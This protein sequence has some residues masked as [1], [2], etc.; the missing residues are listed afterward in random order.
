M[1]KN[2]REAAERYAANHA[3]MMAM[4][5]PR[6]LPYTYI[7]VSTGAAGM[8]N[9]AWNRDAHTLA[10]AYL[11]EHD[12][13]P[14]TE[15]WLRSVGFE[16]DAEKWPGFPTWTSPPSKKVGPITHIHH[17]PMEGCDGWCV[18]HRADGS[19]PPMETRGDVRLL[20]RAL[21]I[22]LSDSDTRKG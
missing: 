14:I 20:A 11:A 16:S 15:D 18:G 6:E 2:V 21:G 3:G 8:C 7:E 17:N 22:Q 4:V 5:H 13:T 1:D 10:R 12:P 9:D 19:I